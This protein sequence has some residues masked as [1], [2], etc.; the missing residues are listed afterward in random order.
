MKLKQ[1]GWLLSALVGLA[2]SASQASANLLA[3]PGFESP[4]TM[5]GAPFVGFWE[6]FN[7]GAGSSAV[8]ST[9]MPRTGA[10]HL[11]GTIS[12]VNNTFAGVF[13]DVEGLVPGQTGVWSVWQKR[14]TPLDLDVEMRIEWRKVGQ[15]AEVARTP[16]FVPTADITEQYKK[17]SIAGVVPAGAD[18]ARVVWAIQTFSGGAGNTGLECNFL[19]ATDGWQLPIPRRITLSTRVS[20]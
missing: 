15:A 16:N 6:S 5:D 9:V 12:N 11:D 19:D 17:F 20:F 18:T 2:L 1:C 4:I 8:I 10:Q 14:T 13:Q 7:G 3:N